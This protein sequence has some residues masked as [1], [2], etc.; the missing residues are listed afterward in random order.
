VASC[1]SRYSFIGLSHTDFSAV[2]AKDDQH[3][4]P[5]AASQRFCPPYTPS[6]RRMS[7]PNSRV[8]ISSG[9]NFYRVIGGLKVHQSRRLR[10]GIPALRNG[11][12][13]FPKF[14]HVAQPDHDLVPTRGAWGRH[15]I[16]NV[17]SAR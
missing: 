6:L 10:A 15:L 4:F 2:H 12:A 3:G 17:V 8:P 7:G 1:D 16:F 5:A 13:Q 9:T 11:D 14:G